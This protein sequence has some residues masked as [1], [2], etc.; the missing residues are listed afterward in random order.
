M[1]EL[2]DVGTGTEHRALAME[3]NRLHPGVRGGAFA[4]FQQLLAQGLGKGIDRAA[5]EADQGQGIFATIMNQA[6]HRC[7]LG[8]IQEWKPPAMP[9]AVS[10]TR[11][12]ESASC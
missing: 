9:G 5:S 6:F 8:R 4:G 2:A 3:D 10:S 12:P 7:V 11:F 1:A